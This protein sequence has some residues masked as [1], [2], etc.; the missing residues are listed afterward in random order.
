VAPS[1]Q[2]YARQQQEFRFQLEAR[3]KIGRFSSSVSRLGTRLPR[4]RRARRIKALLFSRS[5]ERDH[6]AQPHRTWETTYYEEEFD[7]M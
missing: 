3:P 2:C 1:A 5:N 7:Y 6:A 4:L